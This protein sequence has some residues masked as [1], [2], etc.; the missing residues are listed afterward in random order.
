MADSALL[1]VLSGALG[2]TLDPNALVPQ[3]L[4]EGI[5]PVA[6][7]MIGGNWAD[8]QNQV[9][10]DLEA[11]T[12]G[13]GTGGEGTT[14][15][16]LREGIERFL[17]TD[18]NNP[19]ASAKAQSEIW[20]MG[21]SISTNVESYNHI[22]GGS[23]ILYLDGHVAYSRYPVGGFGVAPVNNALANSFFIIDTVSAL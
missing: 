22:P 14:I 19:A 9:Q 7:N 18:I 2:I 8:A 21:D 4:L 17:V 5:L 13:M 1:S 3:Q 11:S 20:I 23:N 16:R 12:P 15:Y 6:L 10:E